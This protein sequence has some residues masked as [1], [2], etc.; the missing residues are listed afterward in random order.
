MGLYTT[1]S[2]DITTAMKSKEKKKL[3]VL[4]MIK[5]KI[6]TVDARGN[7]NDEE[8][9]KI[10]TSYEKNLKDAFNIAKENNKE[11]IS[12]ELEEELEIVSI[13]LPKKLSK[14][15]TEKVVAEVITETNSS[16]KKDMGKVM[17]AIMKKGLVLDG[18]LVKEIVESKLA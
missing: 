9:I 1:I 14:T 4:R 12:K 18:Q 3:D 7:L 11:E 16:T 2:E 8:I 10:I 13:Y 6:M 15:E 17:G 5:S